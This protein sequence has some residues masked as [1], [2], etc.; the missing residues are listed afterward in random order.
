M[1]CCY[2]KVIL[3]QDNFKFAEDFV[4]FVKCRTIEI[5]K[6]SHRRQFPFRSHSGPFDRR[7]AALLLHCCRDFILPLSIPPKKCMKRCQ[8]C[9]LLHLDLSCFVLFAALHCC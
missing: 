7:I 5:M 8:D 4:V 3:I 9:K 6:L 2:C 1:L